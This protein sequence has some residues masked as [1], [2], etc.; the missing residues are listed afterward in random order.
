MSERE[1]CT[2]VRVDQGYLIVRDLK[3]LNE[4]GTDKS[5]VFEDRDEAERF[6]NLL[7]FVRQQ[8]E[9]GVPE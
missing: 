3:V 9:A 7:R 4:P 2:I 5:M 8:L 6:I 1:G